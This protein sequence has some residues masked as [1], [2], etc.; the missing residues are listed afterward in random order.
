MKRIKN[1]N[2][3]GVL[4]CLAVFA[5]T[6][7]SSGRSRRPTPMQA[8]WQQQQRT[9]GPV[10][11]V[12]V[13]RTRT[14]ATLQQKP[15]LYA[16]PKR[17]E[18]QKVV[19]PPIARRLRTV[20]APVEPQ[21]MVSGECQ[22]ESLEILSPEQFKELSLE[23]QQKYKQK[24]M[25]L[26]SSFEQSQ[27]KKEVEKQ[28]PE[29]KDE[30]QRS[31]Q[32]LFERYGRTVPTVVE[33]EGQKRV[34][35]S[36]LTKRLELISGFKE[37]LQ[38][39]VALELDLKKPSKEIKT[40]DTF[41]K[42]IT[43]SIDLIEQTVDSI[44]QKV[45]VE[46]T[47]EQVDWLNSIIPDVVAR[48]NSAI[49][50]FQS[51]LIAHTK[52]LNIKDIDL[53]NMV[54]QYTRFDEKYIQFIAQWESFIPKTQE[55][56]K[57]DEYSR[58][59]NKLLELRASEQITGT[60]PK[61]LQQK[62]PFIINSASIN[63]DDRIKQMAQYLEPA[64]ENT[65]A[66]LL[67]LIISP[68]LNQAKITSYEDFKKLTQNIVDN[69]SNFPFFTGILLPDQEKAAWLDAQ[70]TITGITRSDQEKINRFN[71][72]VK[73]SFVNIKNAFDFFY[74][75]YVVL[76]NSFNDSEYKERRDKITEKN[77][78]PLDKKE[79]FDAVRRKLE[80]IKDHIENINSNYNVFKK[81]IAGFSFGVFNQVMGIIAQY[82]DENH[83]KPYNELCKLYNQKIK[84]KG[85]YSWG[86]TLLG[87]GFRR[88][89]KLAPAEIS[90]LYKE[91]QE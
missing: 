83:I 51:V 65:V 59:I 61:E 74:T 54:E 1:R 7:A 50:N 31:A 66:Y 15:G 3:K 70:K 60:I 16:A 86:N 9:Q 76:I 55:Y 80:L 45:G 62:V 47:H 21:E 18:R 78:N 41:V 39:I 22:K 49:K 42:K 40:V 46:V 57:T 56:L 68:L 64:K 87:F 67:N 84:E 27:A 19:L 88:N 10:R 58:F 2:V 72:E 43:G 44:L 4:F 11:R 52:D 90:L 37:L 79:Q 48:F 6:Y 91:K 23:D 34:L 26:V 82:I 30:P 53:Q 75:K 69:Y 28:E 25:A 38:K 24:I 85:L 63:I 29:E 14:V 73:D 89:A 77:L 32:G 8:M 81:E 17:D 71:K 12:A 36:E 35:Q 33:S 13:P 20:I 5:N